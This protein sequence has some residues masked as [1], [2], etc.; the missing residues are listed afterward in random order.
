MALIFETFKELFT[1]MTMPAYDMKIEG[2]KGKA[3]TIFYTINRFCYFVVLIL[4]D[5]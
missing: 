3:A 4:S 2:A 5:T 1:L